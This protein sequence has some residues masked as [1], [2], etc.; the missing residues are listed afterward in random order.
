MSSSSRSWAGIASLNISNRD[1]KKILE[2][3]LEKD[4]PGPFVIGEQETSI[5]LGKLKIEAKHFTGIS[6]C[7]GGKGLI[8]VTLGR[9]Q[10]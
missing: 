6:I 9:V 4:S 5:L 1:K 10:W 3:R 7:P 8:Y 2:I